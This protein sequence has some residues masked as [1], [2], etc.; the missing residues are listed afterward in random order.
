MTQMTRRGFLRAGSLVMAATAASPLLVS[1]VNQIVQPKKYWDFGAAWSKND[2]VLVLKRLREMLESRISGCVG[3]FGAPPWP[4]QNR[5]FL[6]RYIK[7]CLEQQIAAGFVFDYRVNEAFLPG[8]YE[9][10]VAPAQPADHIVANVSL[11][12]G[13]LLFDA[14]KEAK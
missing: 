12:S 5:E 3:E 9:V 7:R 1:A 2:R 4:R 10:E 14:S 6:E 13:G 11:V 8:C